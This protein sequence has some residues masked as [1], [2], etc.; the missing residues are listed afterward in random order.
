L[1]NVLIGEKII[2]MRIILTL[3]I[4]IVSLQSWTKAE[5]IREFEIEGMSIGESLLD[6]FSN[7]EIINATKTNYPSSKKYQLVHILANSDIYD[8]FTFGI[9]PGDTKYIIY[10]IGGDTNFVDDLTGCLNQKEK[11]VEEVSS[12]FTNTIKKSYTHKYKD[13]DDGKSISKV[14]DLNFQ[15]GSAIRIYCNSW[16]KETEKKRNFR[17]M[18]TVEISPKEFLDWLNTEAY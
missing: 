9:K 7:E 17:D 16:T 12:V 10:S 14:T 6:Y 15:D 1:T 13:I 4:L 2:H 3:I 11:I 18:L 5:D 8:Q